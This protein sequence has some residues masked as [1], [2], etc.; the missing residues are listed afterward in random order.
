[1]VLKCLAG[2]RLARAFGDLRRVAVE[3]EHRAAD[4]VGRLEAQ[5]PHQHPFRQRD[6]SR[7]VERPERNRRTGEERAQTI[8]DVTLL[9]IGALALGDVARDGRLADDDAAGVDDRR[10]RQRHVDAVPVLG[11]ADRLVVREVLAATHPRE[12]VRFFVRVLGWHEPIDRLADHLCRG[13]AIKPLRAGI[14]A[15]RDP[16]ERG[17]EDRVLRRV[18]NRREEF[19]ACLRLLPLRDVVIVQDDRADGRVVQ[20]VHGDH[21]PVTPR[22]ITMPGAVLGADPVPRRRQ[23]LR[24]CRPNARL[25]VRVDEFE[26]APADDLTGRIP[27]ETLDRVAD[28]QHRALRVEQRDH[29]RTVFEDRRKM[30]FAILQ[31]IQHPAVLQGVAERTFEQGRSHLSLDEVV[32]GARVHRIAIDAA[33][34][35]AG[36]HDE[37]RRAAARARGPQQIDPVIF[38]ETIVDQRD[39]VSPFQQGRE[40]ALVGRRPVER[41]RP[42]AAFSRSVRVSRNHPHH[43]RSKHG[44]ESVMPQAAPPS[45]ASRD[46]EGTW[47]R[48]GRHLRGGSRRRSCRRGAS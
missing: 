17:A 29:V 1:M 20:S 26:C 42:A 36:Q 10:N 25:V 38:A 44:G 15:H 47:R 13:V 41:D 24:G 35:V 18:H 30:F 22:P 8:G 34:G 2:K 5:L 45:S 9:H 11:D 31:Q 14:P 16:F 28:K 3:I 4:K 12:D 43:R 40:A 19:A 39:V 23:A 33:V 7:R 21:F 6:D 48:I 32:V 27:N 37:R 46:R